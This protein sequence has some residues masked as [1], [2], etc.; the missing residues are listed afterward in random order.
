M[1]SGGGMDGAQ[2]ANLMIANHTPHYVSSPFLE[3]EASVVFISNSYTL[4]QNVTF[5]FLKPQHFL[6]AIKIGLL[7]VKRSCA[8]CV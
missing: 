4:L 7:N 1:V 2:S 6:L 5:F 3:A 8:T